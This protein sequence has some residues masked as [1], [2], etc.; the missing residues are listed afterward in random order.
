[1]IITETGSVEERSFLLEPESPLAASE[2][3]ERAGH[4][5][6][7]FVVDL[8]L[9]VDECLPLQDIKLFLVVMTFLSPNLS[10]KEFLPPTNELPF[11][12]EDDELFCFVT[13][14]PLLRFLEIIAVESTGGLCCGL[15][16]LAV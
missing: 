10:E 15:A 12:K 1:M 2:T 5:E 4:R 6:I 3:E 9:E 7:T 11:I 16:I 14:N 8:T 13:L